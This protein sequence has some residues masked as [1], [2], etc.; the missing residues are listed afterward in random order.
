M[1]YKVADLRKKLNR[2]KHDSRLKTDKIARLMKDY[3][4]V[5]HLNAEMEK[6]EE[7]LI[8]MIKAGGIKLGGPTMI[9]TND[10]F[11]AGIQWK[12]LKDIVFELVNKGTIKVIVD[13]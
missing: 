2:L 9:G 3:E 11:R 12:I 8:D 6:A 10:K 13:E 1:D 5:V 4:K 7:S